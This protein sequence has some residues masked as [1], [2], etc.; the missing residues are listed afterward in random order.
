[1]VAAGPYFFAKGE[2][3]GIATEI[4]VECQRDEVFGDKFG[5]DLGPGEP[6]GAIGSASTSRTGQGTPIRGGEDYERLILRNRLSPCFGNVRQPRNLSPRT[7]SRLWLNLT[8]Q[9]CKIPGW[10]FRQRFNAERGGGD[11]KAQNN[12]KTET[13]S[14]GCAPAIGF[15][16]GTSIISW[17]FVDRPAA[18]AGLVNV[19]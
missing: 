7:F 6:P 10:N 15:E 16:I 3:L 8:K 17:P 14:H 2:F 12:A 18:A 19:R 1:M 5:L 4:S 11:D 13:Q 9:P